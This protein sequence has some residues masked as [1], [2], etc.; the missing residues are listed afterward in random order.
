MDPSLNIKVK[1][2]QSNIVVMSS[3]ENGH[4]L[5]NNECDLAYDHIHFGK[6]A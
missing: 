4:I 6:W 2:R 3:L 5:Y 1:Y